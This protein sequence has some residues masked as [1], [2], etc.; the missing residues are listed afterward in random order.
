MAELHEQSSSDFERFAKRWLRALVAVFLRAVREPAL[1]Y[2]LATETLATARLRWGS[3]PPDPHRVAWLLELGAGVIAAAVEHRRVPSIERLRN[4]RPAPRTLTVAEQHQLMA[5][6]ETRFELPADAQAQAET[7]ARMA[8]PV[9]VLR[10]IR[11]SSLVHA[12]PLPDRG[13]DRHEH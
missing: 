1:A 4:Q 2:D 6:A 3:A 7:F 12:E 9:H 8:P 5:L 13:M 10:E 11:R